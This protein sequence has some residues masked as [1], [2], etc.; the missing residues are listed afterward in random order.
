MNTIYY[1][2]NIHSSLRWLEKWHCENMTL[3]AQNMEPNIPSNGSKKPWT[4][5]CVGM[6]TMKYV[7]PCWIYGLAAYASRKNMNY[8]MGRPNLVCNVKEKMLEAIL[9]NG[10]VESQTLELKLV[11]DLSWMWWQFENNFKMMLENQYSCTLFEMF[12]WRWYVHF[13]DNGSNGRMEA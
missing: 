2:H 10:W 8:R 5:S 3:F 9:K 4:A 12:F 1:K 6:C 13:F 7:Y 11:Q